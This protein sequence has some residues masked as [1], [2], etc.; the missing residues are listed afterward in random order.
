MTINIWCDA[1]VKKVEM[2]P[3]NP[4]GR[5]VCFA[6]FVSDRGHCWQD[7]IYSKNSHQAEICAVMVALYWALEQGYQIINLHT[8]DESIVGRLGGKRK[9]KD[10]GDLPYL[11]SEGKAEVSVIVIPRSQN[12]T[13]HKL[14]KQAY[15]EYCQGII[16]PR[17]ARKRRLYLTREAIIAAQRQGLMRAVASMVAK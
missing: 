9:G 10:M 2:T 16:F 15:Q 1:S 13:A 4:R 6:A 5:S 17:K 7:I 11:I 14:C 12:R 3:L 8:D